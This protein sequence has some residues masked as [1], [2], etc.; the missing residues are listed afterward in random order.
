MTTTSTFAATW[1]TRRRPSPR[2]CGRTWSAACRKA[3]SPRSKT[4]SRSSAFCPGHVFKER[5]ADYY[6]FRDE[7][8]SRDDL[9]HI[10]ENDACVKATYARMTHKLETLVEHRQKRFCRTCQAQRRGL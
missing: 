3:K 2:T 6:D 1:T 8:T 7:I 4:S 9:K 5:D 10:V